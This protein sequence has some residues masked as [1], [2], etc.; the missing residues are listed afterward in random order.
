MTELGCGTGS[1]L[2]ALCEPAAHLDD[3]PD[4]LPPPPPDDSELTRAELKAVQLRRIER[5]EPEMRELH[6]RRICALDS[7]RNALDQAVRE[8][9]PPPP[10]TPSS[11][12]SYFAPRERWE[13]LRIEIWQGSL[14]FYNESLDGTEVVVASEVIEHLDDPVLKKFGPVVLGT[15][16]PRIVVVTTPNYD[17][18]PHFVASSAEEES[19][20]RIPDPTGRTDRRFRDPDHRFEWTEAEF[21]EWCNGLAREFDYDVE[22]GGVGSLDNYLSR[23]SMLL[24]HLP[25]PSTTPLP[26]AVS[27]PTQ[28]QPLSVEGVPDPKKL[29]ATQTALFRRRYAHEPER[30]PRSPRTVPLP[31][32]GPPSAPEKRHHS[33]VHTNIHHASPYARQPLSLRKIRRVL[34]KTMQDTI[35]AGRASINDLWA[36]GNVRKACGGYVGKIV[37]AVLDDPDDEW[38]FEVDETKQ[39][40][41][42]VVVVYKPFVQLGSDDESSLPAAA[43][44]LS[45]QEEEDVGGGGGVD[46]DWGA[47]DSELVDAWE[48]ADNS[49]SNNTD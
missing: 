27:K 14:D 17:F 28:D 43:A 7:D 9:A 39:G 25:S 42:A 48:K 10:P 20:H 47:T 19:A 5:P 32:F 37:E 30:S 40:T 15:Y 21:R 22:I 24:P 45:Q 44:V 18:N 2:A 41:D 4:F 26:S 29:F 34:A 46:Q 13:D 8:T 1:L 35:R 36:M 33:L 49:D 12:S 31:F 11:S 3:F 38:D 23:R 16:R 6:L